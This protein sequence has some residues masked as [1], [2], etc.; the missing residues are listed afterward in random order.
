MLRKSLVLPAI[1]FEPSTAL[2]YD[3]IPVLPL[4]PRIKCLCHA[5]QPLYCLSLIS[6]SAISSTN[7]SNSSAN[8][9]LLSQFLCPLIYIY[10][11]FT[12]QILSHPLRS[13]AISSENAL[14]PVLAQMFFLTYS[15]QIQIL[16][17]ESVATNTFAWEYRRMSLSTIPQHAAPSLT[18]PIRY[19]TSTR[20]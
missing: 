4:H 2:L 1:I 10:I 11:F 9:E 13:T 18:T 7:S 12:S 14:L 20:P 19:R 3:C 16:S 5:H 17:E 6:S 8:R 15:S